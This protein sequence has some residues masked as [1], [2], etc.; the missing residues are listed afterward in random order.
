MVGGLGR[1]R[2]IVEARGEDGLGGFMDR[3]SGQC[4]LLAG[5]GR[6]RSMMQRSW[7]SFKLLSWNKAHAQ[8][9]PG[10]SAI[11]SSTMSNV[12]GW[13]FRFSCKFLVHVIFGKL[14]RQSFCD[15]L[16]TPKFARRAA[17]PVVVAQPIPSCI[18]YFCSWVSNSS[19]YCMN[20]NLGK[21]ASGE[22]LEIREHF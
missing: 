10:R 22:L 11:C 5:N 20:R 7:P 1:G 9:L 21:A 17:N 8:V 14:K 13:F 15:G 6:A 16:Y 2:R 3:E 19:K 18:R 12:N 4:S